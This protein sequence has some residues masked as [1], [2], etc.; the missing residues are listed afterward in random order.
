[1]VSSVDEFVAPAVERDHLGRYLLPDPATGEIRPWTRCTTL[2]ETISDRRA[3]ERWTQR[4]IAR[5]L[6]SRPDL[7]QR[8]LAIDDDRALDGIIDAAA[9]AAGLHA[10]RDFGTA[11]HHYTEEVDLG[12]MTVEQ[13]PAEYRDVVARYRATMDRYGIEIYADPSPWIER[14]VINP[15]F[16]VAGTIDR[17]VIHPDWDL[18]RVL[19]IKTGAGAPKYGQVEIAG[20]LAV[21]ATASHWWDGSLHEMPAIDQDV[22]LVVHV[23]PEVG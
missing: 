5:G 23:P 11:A 2:A 13:V 16:N 19:D 21:Y 15:R 9:E 8:T 17:V 20:Q 14:V 3:L 22:A 6:A 10:K 12:Q 1:M 18:P 4:G 7:V